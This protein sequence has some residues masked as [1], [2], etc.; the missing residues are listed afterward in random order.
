MSLLLSNPEIQSIDSQ[1]NALG[2][3]NVSQYISVASQVSTL[4]TQLASIDKTNVPLYMSTL[5]RL[6]NMQNN[7]LVSNVEEVNTLL[8]QRV[9]LLESL[10]S[11]G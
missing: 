7:A 5:E 2:V 10:T 6:Y 9:Q 3:K 4:K 11:S 1:L 8:A